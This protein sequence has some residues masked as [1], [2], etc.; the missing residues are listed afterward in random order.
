MNQILSNTG[1]SPR[2]WGIRNTLPTK[3]SRKRFI[4]TRVGNTDNPSTQKAVKP[5]HPH[6]CGEY[7]RHPK[8]PPRASRFI[9][10]RVG[11]TTE[12]SAPSGVLTVHPHACGEYNRNECAIWSFNGSSPRVWGI[13][14]VA[15]NQRRTARFIPTRVGNTNPSLMTAPQNTGSSPRVWGILPCFLP[16]QM[17]RRFIPTRVGNTPPCSCSFSFSTVHPHACGEYESGELLDPESNRFIPTRVG[18]TQFQYGSV[19]QVTVHPH[20][21]GEYAIPVWLRGASDGSSPRVWGILHQSLFIR[22]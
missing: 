9:P 10:T 13:L 17:L 5:V 15:R 16:S 1:S 18:N 19:V 2:V 4:P 11:N 22:P 14:L 8:V 20:A 3:G 12:T 6:A 7:A 21:C